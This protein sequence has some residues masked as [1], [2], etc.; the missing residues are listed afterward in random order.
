[1]AKKKFPKF[2]SASYWNNAKAGDI[3]YNRE[4]G[5]KVGLI[6]YKG[7]IK[8]RQRGYSMHESTVVYGVYHN[9]IVSTSGEFKLFD[10]HPNL[11]YAYSS[12]PEYGLDWP[13]RFKTKFLEQLEKLSKYHWDGFGCENPL[14][15]AIKYIDWSVI[16]EIT[17]QDRFL[18]KL[19]KLQ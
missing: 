18:F 14:P 6:L 7:E 3:I 2:D 9:C 15:L 11:K 1:M 12:D 10:Y 13:P 19:N 17:E 16:P 4:K 8:I 5:S